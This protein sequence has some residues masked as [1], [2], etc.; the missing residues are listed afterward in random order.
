MFIAAL[1]LLTNLGL[2]ITGQASTA[3]VVGIGDRKLFP[4][5]S[6]GFGSMTHMSRPANPPAVA[7]VGLSVPASFGGGHQILK[8]SIPK[9]TAQTC[10]STIQRR[11]VGPADTRLLRSYSRTGEPNASHVTRQDR[12]PGRRNRDTD[13]RSRL[14]L[15]REPPLAGPPGVVLF[16]AT[17]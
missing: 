16:C 8:P 10:T 7:P 5:R 13:N 6:S 12:H 1:S 17:P 2:P 11:A 15:N 14:R 4:G 9:R 3:K